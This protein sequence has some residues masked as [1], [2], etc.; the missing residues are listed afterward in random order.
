[1][2]EMGPEKSGRSMIVTAWGRPGGGSTA[3]AATSSTG[4][5]NFLCASPI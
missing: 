2:Y 3:S 4:R 5:P 1:V